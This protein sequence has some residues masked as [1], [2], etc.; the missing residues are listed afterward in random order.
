MLREERPGRIGHLGHAGLAH[1]EDPDLLGRT[2]PVLRS[3]HEAEGGVAL[4]LEGKDRVD[5]VFQ[6]LRPGQ[7]AILR[8]VSDKDDRDALP[9]R[10]LHQPQ[11]GLADLADAPG[12]PLELADGRGLDGVDDDE[13]GP[14]IP[15]DLGDPPDLR[16]GDDPDPL[17]AG[18]IEQAQPRRPQP[19]L[20]GRLLAGRV[21]DAGAGGGDARGSLEEERRLADPRFATDQDDRTL[22]QP[23]TQHTIELA[24]PD[25]PARDIWLGNGSK[26]NGLGEPAGG[27]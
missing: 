7:R 17:A 1:V 21:E 18:S 25:R 22:D 26:R 2:K 10:E 5:E 8:D 6:R 11:R 23:A 3:P 19:D 4:A 20:G 15:G 9:L 24:D 14:L 16:L 13:L 27:R 12:R